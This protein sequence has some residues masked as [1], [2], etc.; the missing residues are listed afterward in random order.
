VTGRI[1][2]SLSLENPPQDEMSVVLAAPNL[3]QLAGRVAAVPVPPG[4]FAQSLLSGLNPEH[5]PL[6]F[7]SQVEAPFVED[8]GEDRYRPRGAA[9]AVHSVF[10]SRVPTSSSS[11]SSSSSEISAKPTQAQNGWEGISNVF[12]SLLTSVVKDIE[13]LAENLKNGSGN[14]YNRLISSLTDTKSKLIRRMK[15]YESNV[16]KYIDRFVV[17]NLVIKYINCFNEVTLKQKELQKGKA[18]GRPPKLFHE[19]FDGWIAKL[20][21]KL[22]GPQLLKFNKMAVF[23]Y[24]ESLVQREGLKESLVKLMGHFDDLL[25]KAKSIKDNTPRSKERRYINSKK[26]LFIKN[27][28]V[29]VERIARY[30]NCPE[31]MDLAKA[32]G[33]KIEQLSQWQA[34]TQKQTKSGGTMGIQALSV[35]CPDLSNL[36][37]ASHS[38]GQIQDLSGLPKNV[39]IATS[40]DRAISK[41]KSFINEHSKWFQMDKKSLANPKIQTKVEGVRDL[42]RRTKEAVVRLSTVG[43]YFRAENHSNLN[44]IASSVEQLA[45]AYNELGE[46]QAKCLKA[47]DILHFYDTFKGFAEKLRPYLDEDSVVFAPSPIT[48]PKCKRMVGQEPKVVESEKHSKAL[49]GK[50]QVVESESESSESEESSDTSSSSSESSSSSSESSSSSSDSSSDSSVVEAPRPKRALRRLSEAETPDPKRRRLTQERSSRVDSAQDD[51]SMDLVAVD[52]P[53]APMLAEQ[54]LSSLPQQ[55]LPPSMVPQIQA[56]PASMPVTPLVQTISLEERYTNLLGRLKQ[57]KNLIPGFSVKLTKTKE[58]LAIDK[59][60]FFDLHFKKTPDEKRMIIS[61]HIGKLKNLLGEVWRSN[62]TMSQKR[63]FVCQIAVA[64][65][66]VICRATPSEFGG[67][68]D[69]V[70]GFAETLNPLLKDDPEL[71]QHFGSKSFSMLFPA[72]TNYCIKKGDVTLLRR[73]FSPRESE[74]LFL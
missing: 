64:L 42:C 68:E 38:S 60:D 13:E 46:F 47:K 24:S 45:A 26:S 52:P 29:L 74:L 20:Q 17:L 2:P 4:S 65:N 70:A 25:D 21:D 30:Q 37:G 16:T 9:A 56:I 59:L 66:H 39:P 8:V 7:L 51:S 19:A 49:R 71:L 50:R 57:A 15:S 43:K 5:I 14:D 72:F 61:T 58:E 62:E 28:N 6:S 55:L 44:E 22:K 41:L 54:M 33:M 69:L 34:E 35:V 12:K 11:S 67:I 1:T 40:I 3:V 18:P 32:L 36:I 48:G 31:I 63:A 23:P 10:A 73:I 53:A 27:T